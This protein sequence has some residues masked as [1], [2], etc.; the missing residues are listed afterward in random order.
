[1]ANCIIS[2]K[3]WKKI[4]M[5][6][7]IKDKLFLKAHSYVLGNSFGNSVLKFECWT[8]KKKRNICFVLSLIEKKREFH[9]TSFLS[10]QNLL[11]FILSNRKRHNNKNTHI[12]IISPH[13]EI[14]RSLTQVLTYMYHRNRKFYASNMSLKH[15][16]ISLT[17]CP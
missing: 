15:Q 3:R 7:H 16:K 8:L 14:V 13:C 1:M 17:I 5:Q 9:W 11:Y 12:E 2:N 6:S 10:N 4:A